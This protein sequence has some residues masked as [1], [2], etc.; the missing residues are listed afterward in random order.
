[1]ATKKKKG[2]MMG[3]LF[4]NSKIC[5]LFVRLASFLSDKAES[6]ITG[7]VFSSYDEDS[8]E[9]GIFHGVTKK[10]DL[11]KVFFRP[12]KRFVS[13][14]FSNSVLINAANGFLQGML[15]TKLNVY[16][17][18]FITSGIGFLLSNIL[19]LYIHR[20]ERLSFVDTAL[21]AILVLLALPLLF[22]SSTLNKAVYTSKS[23]SSFV[24]GWLGCRRETYEKDAIYHGHSKT[25]LPFALLLCVVSWWVRPVY[26]V[27]GIILTVCA[28][29]ALYSPES[30]ILMLITVL[31]FL[32]FE[33][34]C[35]IIAYT[36]VCFV[37]KYV[38]GKR[39]V[40]FDPL[41][42]AVLGFCIIIL[43][44]YYTS[45]V[46]ALAKAA[47][48]QTI[49]GICLFFLVI[50]L[51]KSKKWINRCVCSVCIA[52]FFAAVYGLFVYVAGRFE[53]D[54]MRMILQNGT[55]RSF[56]SYFSDTVHLSQYLMICLLFIL[57]SFK[58][59]GGANRGLTFCSFVLCTVCFI[60]TGDYRS[61]ICI[62]LGMLLVMTLYSKKSLAFTIFG[63]CLMPFA[64]ATV[65]PYIRERLA[66]SIKVSDILS[67]EGGES[68]SARQFISHIFSGKGIGSCD[69]IY[70]GSLGLVHRLAAEIG[71]V[72]LIL[73]IFILF[74][75]LQK[76]T[77][78]YSHGCSKQGRLVSLTA[79]AAAYSLVYR[80]VDVNIF[81][82]H[83]VGLMFWF[84]IA[85]ASCVSVTERGACRNDGLP[86]N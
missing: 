56:T 36:A 65:Y 41:A 4:A 42:T 64:A 18:V 66:L 1:M 77:T 8:F 37:L 49:C 2:T 7:K 10:L 84:C 12:I 5:G 23:V 34:L 57:A 17:L 70:G 74:F 16:G 62:I 6:G 85:L 15:Y 19:K 73:F 35:Y 86:E 68:L 50:N 54:Y 71:L 43:F 33:R 13:R 3:R 24:F 38:R 31:P 29:V 40:K 44:N 11:G 25:A 63:L 59:D 55:L 45:N 14:L 78:L 46:G 22:S 21:S 26:I 60:L 69:G 53:I 67:L 79:I 76:N 32:S 48:M 61:F 82:D 20:L 28:L 47:T 52:A 72:G 83:R 39:T 58:K 30:A 80:G 51:I 75:V 27:F 9:K 81:A